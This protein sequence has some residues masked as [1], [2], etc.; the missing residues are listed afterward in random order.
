MPLLP[1]LARMEKAGVMID[2]E[3]LDAMSHEFTAT[4]AGLEARIYALVGHEFNIGSP[5]QLETI[6]F[7]ELACH[8]RSG[9]ERA[10]RRMHRFSRSCV[11]STR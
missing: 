11:S 2:L 10:A 4:L 6:L 9:R 7:D 3:A 8:R 5:R 1:V